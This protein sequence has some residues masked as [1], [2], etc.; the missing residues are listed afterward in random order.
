MLELVFM[1]GGFA[2]K[3]LWGIT[4]RLWA[5]GKPLQDRTGAADIAT[6]PPC[7]EGEEWALQGI[8]GI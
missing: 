1:G 3:E 4:L 7:E 8:V 6:V 5:T 2:A